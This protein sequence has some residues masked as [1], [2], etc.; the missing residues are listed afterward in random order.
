VWANSVSL[1]IPR[2]LAEHPEI[3]VILL[4]DAFQHQS[5]RPDINILLT[6]YFKPFYDDLILPLGTLR[7]FSSGKDRANIIVVTKCPENLSEQEQME[8]V[9]KIKPAFWTEGIFQQYRIRGAL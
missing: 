5:V 3:K 6:T 4:D 2:L 9:Q 7:E 8:I 1:P